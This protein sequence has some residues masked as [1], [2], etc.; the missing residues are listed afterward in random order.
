M[1]AL[2]AAPV[3][4]TPRLRLRGPE[5][6]DLAAYT[7]FVTASPVLQARGETVT[8]DQAWY[9][10]LTGVGHW[11]WHGFGFF[12]VVDRDTG[13]AVG[14]V[15]LL[16]HSRW[17][18]VELAWHLYQGAEG[19]GFAT[20]AALAVRTWAYDVL[21]VARLCSYI[22]RGNLHSQAVARR[23]GAVTDGTRAAHEP[24]AEV[25]LHPR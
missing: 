3:L 21:A 5:R 24:E 25:W 20:E 10:F 8:E 2:T 22:D 12:V 4:E 23:L 17:Q 1:P 14:R 16:R 11:H 6:G 7:R 19:R 13:D 18:D 9:A 15:G